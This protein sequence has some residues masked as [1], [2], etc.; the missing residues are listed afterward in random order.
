MTIYGVEDLADFSLVKFSGL[1]GGEGLM[2]QGCQAYGGVVRPT[3]LGFR[4]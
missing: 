2:I 1:L 3:L 4:G